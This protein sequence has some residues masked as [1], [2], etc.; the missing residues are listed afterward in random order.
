MIVILCLF[1]GCGD[2]RVILH[3][4]DS[5]EESIELMQLREEE[6]IQRQLSKRAV[7]RLYL[8]DPY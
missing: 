8:F 3:V 6:A 1:S 2:H 5:V 4:M 7:A